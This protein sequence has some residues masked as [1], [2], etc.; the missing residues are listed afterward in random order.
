VPGVLAS[1]VK[2]EKVRWFWPGRIPRGK[3]TMFDGDPGLGKSMVSLDLAA[4]A[5]VG[6]RMPDGSFPEI[7]VSGAV[8][9]SLED[10]I[11][12]TIVPRLV[13]AGADRTRVRVVE[14]ITGPDGIDRT[15]TIPVDLPAIEAAIEDVR[16]TLLV[17]DPLVATLGADTNSYK[18][19]DV[20]RA[21]APLK[22][23]AEKTGVAVI[24]IRHVNKSNDPNPKYRGGGSIGLTG[25]ARA[26]FV[27]GEDPDEEGAFVMAW[28]KGNLASKP[29]AMKYRLEDSE[30]GLVVS[31]KGHSHHT[32]K[33]ILAEPETQEES[34]ALRDA[35]NFIEELLKDGPMDA[36]EVKREARAAGIS[37]R[38]LIRARYMSSI[39][40]QKCGFGSGQH[41]EWQLTKDAKNESLASFDQA[42]ET[43]AFI[44]NDSPKDAKNP[45]YT[46]NL[47][48]FVE[49]SKT[50]PV[51]SSTLSKDAKNGDL[52][53]FAGT[54]SS[55]SSDAEEHL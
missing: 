39:K 5:S 49:N 43:Q 22:V 55:Q 1:E 13:A 47:A 52:A 28:S 34:N 11:A 42:T 18:D 14:V 24:A 25:L 46:E 23:L 44:Q 9:V 54:N 6:A 21:L 12:D 15:P 17:I 16:A 48:S 37:E 20:R 40:T 36:R 7:T 8:I 41:W 26:N 30:R 3:V 29:P 27:F 51:K 53:S 4:R 50:T 2:P 45:I 35:K 19:Q 31:W 10:G 33:S 32:A 38:T